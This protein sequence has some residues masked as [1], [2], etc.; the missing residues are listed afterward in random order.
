MCINIVLTNTSL[1]TPADIQVW[2]ECCGAGRKLIWQ[3]QVPANP[4]QLDNQM[5]VSL[6]YSGGSID[7]TANP[8]TV[9]WTAC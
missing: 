6:P 9:S 8:A 3:G 4:S 5:V 7:I 1:T 2:E